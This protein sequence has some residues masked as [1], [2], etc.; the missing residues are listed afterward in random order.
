[1]DNYGDAAGFIDYHEK[2]GRVIPA[3]WKAN[4]NAVIEQALIVASE[5][6]DRKFANLFIGYK[7]G[8]YQQARE[9]PRKAAYS[10]NTIPNYV[11]GDAEIPAEM[12]SATYEVAFRQATKP[13]VLSLDY[14]PNKYKTVRVDGAV[15]IEYANI[16]TVSE[17]QMQIADLDAIL[18]PLFDLCG[19]TSGYSGSSQ[20]T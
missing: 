1:M 7:S 14:T 10:T 3:S 18:A 5:W 6:V 12:S 13:G 4:S 19:P 17:I 9:W 2:R 15:S 16:N 8:G 20:R 11:F